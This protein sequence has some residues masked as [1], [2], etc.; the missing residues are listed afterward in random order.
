[1]SKRKR[2]K[3]EGSI[4][5]RKDGRWAGFVTVGY[6][7]DGSQIKKWVYGK[8]RREAAEKLAKLL[9]KA[10]SGIVPEPAK[11]TVGEWLE[12]YARAKA[13]E[14]RPN[15]SRHYWTY[16][17]YLRP[18]HRLRLNAVQPLHI[19]DVYEKLAERGL[20]PSVRRHV[21]HF[22]KGA[23]KEALKLDSFVCYLIA[24]PRPS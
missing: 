16:I 18:L 10:G 8:S 11:L 3:G 9:P 22:L 1:M 7:A 19:Q 21:H 12:R 20:S 17:E 4:F 23:F 6:A 2:G 24:P 13:K 15:T 5:Q 14:V